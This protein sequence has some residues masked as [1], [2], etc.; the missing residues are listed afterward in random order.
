MFTL[1]RWIT[2]ST[3]SWKACQSGQCEENN[4]R[5]SQ[6]STKERN[7]KRP[8]ISGDR[9]HSPGNGSGGCS[10]LATICDGQQPDKHCRNSQSSSPRSSAFGCEVDKIPPDSARQR[11]LWQGQFNK[12][13]RLGLK[14]EIWVKQFCFKLQSASSQLARAADGICK[15]E[16]SVD[17]REYYT[18][19]RTDGKCNNLKNQDTKVLGPWSLFQS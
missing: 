14:I 9:V 19:R 2:V 8:G 16:D 15:A 11:G 4:R 18:V 17:C 13:E 1:S 12:F 10:S 5:P 7:H 3:R 6:R